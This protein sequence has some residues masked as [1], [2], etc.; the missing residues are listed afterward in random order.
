MVDITPCLLQNCEEYRVEVMSSGVMH[1]YHM[2][3]NTLNCVRSATNFVIL[4]ILNYSVFH[5][6]FRIRE[7]RVS[8]REPFK[9]VLIFQVPELSFQDAELDIR[10]REL[11]FYFRCSFDVKELKTEFGRLNFLIF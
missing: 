5:P 9:G 10:T 8:K 2:F 11:Y 1:K 7:Y 3:P 6:K 4:C